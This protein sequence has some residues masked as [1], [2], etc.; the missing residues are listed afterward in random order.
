MQSRNSLVTLGGLRAQSR[1]DRKLREDP[2][3]TGK[4][5]WCI[6]QRATGAILELGV[7][8]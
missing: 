2:K 7:L 3:K 1:C 6:S 4:T 8:A 5:F